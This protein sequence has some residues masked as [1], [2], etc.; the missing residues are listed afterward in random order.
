MTRHKNLIFLFI[1]TIVSILSSLV[2]WSELVRYYTHPRQ[3][4]DKMHGETMKLIYVY[5]FKLLYQII[6]SASRLY[7]RGARWRNG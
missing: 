3:P 5:A 2:F 6:S 4:V 1:V 7:S